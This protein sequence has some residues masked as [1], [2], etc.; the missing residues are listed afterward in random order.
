[1]A[2]SVQKR[3]RANIPP[4]HGQVYYATE[5]SRRKCHGKDIA[6]FKH[7]KLIRSPLEVYSCVIRVKQTEVMIVRTEKI[8]LLYGL[9]VKVSSFRIVSYKTTRNSSRVF[10]RDNSKWHQVQYLK[11]IGLTIGEFDWLIF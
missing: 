5:I 2:R 1:M 10:V 8:N 6:Y 11:N 3:A 9:N 7:A 4:Q